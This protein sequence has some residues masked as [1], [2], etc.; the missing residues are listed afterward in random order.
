MTS[1]RQQPLVSGDQIVRLPLHRARQQRIVVRVRRHPA[2]L[3]FPGGNDGEASET[4]QKGCRV[5]GRESILAREGRSGQHPRQ[6]RQRRLAHHRREGL[7]SPEIEKAIGRGGKIRAKRMRDFKRLDT[8][9]PT[10]YLLASLGA[11]LADVPF[12]SLLT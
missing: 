1:Q 12:Q 9:L 6:L 8:V 7:L 2:D 3:V 10:M 4:P 11:V 5:C